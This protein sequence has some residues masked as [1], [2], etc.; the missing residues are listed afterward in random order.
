MQ[1][2]LKSPRIPRLIKIEIVISSKDECVG[3]GPHSC[4]HS[5]ILD[6]LPWVEV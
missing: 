3:R 4:S 1:K 2:E 6:P 5:L